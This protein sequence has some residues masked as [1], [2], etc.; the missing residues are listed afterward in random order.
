MDLGMKIKVFAKG[1]ECENDGGMRL[2][3]AECGTEIKGDA[4]MGFG[5]EMSQERTVPLEISAVHLWQWEDVVPVGDCSKDAGDKEL[6][7][8]LH[9][10]LVAGRA[11]SA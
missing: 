4:L 5:A 2:G 7:A 8:G 10:F 11:E 9:I 1:V 6:G 3:F